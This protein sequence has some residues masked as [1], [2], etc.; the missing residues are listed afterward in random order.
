MLKNL[1]S[2]LLLILMLTVS[3]AVEAHKYTHQS[4]NWEETPTL[5]SL[6]E[7]EMAA[8]A[9]I[10]KDKRILEYTYGKEADLVLYETT[11]K[12]IRVNSD[13]A[14]E[15]FNKVFVPM[16]DV[17]EF[18]ELK[19]RAISPN[20]K[21]TELNRDNIKELKDVRDLGTLKIFAIEGVEKGGELEYFYTTQSKVGDPYSRSMVQTDTKIKE[22]SIEIISPDNLEFEAKS[23]NGFPDL[24][25][26]KKAVGKGDSV[27]ILKGITTDLEGLREEDYSLHRANLMK[28]AYKLSYNRSQLS[29]RL[30]DWGTAAKLFESS[31]YRYNDKAKALIKD[32]FKDLKAKKGTTEE[33]VKKIEQYIKNNI[34]V[35]VGSGVDYIKVNKILVN[36]Y[37]NEVGLARVFAAMLQEAEIEHE[38]VMTS[39]RYQSRFD[40]DFED[41]S[42]FTEVLFYFPEIDKYISPS[43]SQY[44]LGFAP[45]Q[46]SDNYGLF[47]KDSD[48]WHHKYIDMPTAKQS[49]NRIDANV[50]FD[51]NFGV[52]LDMEYGWTGYRAV[53]FRAIYEFQKED[54]VKNRLKSGVRGA[55]ILESDVENETLNDSEDPK[56]EF[57]IKGKLTTDDLMEKAGRSYL[58]NVGEIIGEQ[59][60]LYQE[61]KRQNPID[62]PYPTHYQRTINFTIPDGYT[63]EG[64]E[65]VKID[66]F[67][68]NKSGEKVNRFLSDYKIDGNKVSITAEEY[69][70]NISLDKEQYENFRSVINAAADFNKVVLVF[71]KKKEEEKEEVQ[72]V[73]DQPKKSVD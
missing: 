9:I 19:A 14:V 8:S 22:A 57:I 52:S 42:N 23:Y 10:I 11:H 2:C 48:K 35:K 46:L 43:A 60:E 12:I 33:K 58:F 62:M 16:G 41:W 31:M 29:P 55:T 24:K 59:V 27:Q 45:Y 34:D 73:K 21:I 39:N 5:H 65:D 71:E 25:K 64:L 30:Y 3:T 63:L 72:P 49:V 15:E 44:R 68:E 36:K 54:F 67:M 50:S 40:K 66:K 4:Y 47:I 51:D 38:M 32:V 7:E 18:V 53:E 61:H 28:V 17:I 56:R 69:Y 13:Q 26:E 37:A 70:E 6:T 20:G 1:I